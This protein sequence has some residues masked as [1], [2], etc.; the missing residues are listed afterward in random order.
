MKPV[1]TNSSPSG[2]RITDMRFVD[3][4]GAPKRCTLI[5]IMTN[6]GLTGYGEVRDA[7]SKLYAQMLK[8]RILGENPCNVD[9]IFRKIKQ[10]GWHSRQGGGVSGVEIAL[11]DL[12]GK[13]YGVPLYQLLGGKFR[14][15]VRVYCDTDVD[16]R[17]TGRDMG[18]ALKKRMDMGFTFL[19]MDLGIGLLMDEPGTINAPL[20]FIDDMKKYAP[21]V[22]NVQGGSVTADMVKH[23]KSYAIVNTAHPFTGIHLTE[24][25][26]D[27]LENY[28][29]EV[30]EVIGYEIPL[31][32]DHFG[33]VCVEDCIR[34]A[35][36]MER[37]NIAW[38]EDM[39]PWMYTDQYVRMRNATTVPVC[40]GEDIYLK[41]DFQ[42]LILA[43]GVSVI[44]PDILTCGGA[45]EL[46]KI[47]DFADEHGVAVAIHMAESP[48]ACMAAVHAAAAM[49]HVLAMEYHSVDVPWWQDMV[50]GLPKPLIR[51][52][53]IQV[54]DGPGLGFEDINEEVVRAHI[55]PNIPGLWESTDQ[56]NTEFSND[57][58]W[59]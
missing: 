31:A 7:S 34:F 37:Y 29:K 18:L 19:K 56:W 28:V 53:F 22:L 57:R 13:A 20:G 10:F 32:I 42:K 25:G 40:T 6:Q 1:N 16:G 8:S 4:D 54:P 50:T 12:A 23:Q 59:S 48:V 46:K 43:G 44:H 26:L 24:K 21:Q 15:E 3:I 38:M 47:A 55:N 33:H 5:K 27:Y 51:N 36:R 35:R 52:G 41:E 2:L 45:L 39:V 58:L 17:H 11:W 49:N 30:R 14:D 9:K